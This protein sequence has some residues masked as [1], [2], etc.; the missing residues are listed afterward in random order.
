MAS[1]PKSPRPMLATL[2]K[3]APGG[4]DWIHELKLDG[5]RILGR[6]DRGAVSLI[7]R[8]GKDWIDRYP[9][10]AAALSG[11]SSVRA[12][13]DGEV[14]VLLPDGRTS[15]QALQSLGGGIGEGTLVY[16]VFDLLHLEGRDLTG[17]PVLERK[18]LLRELLDRF[19]AGEEARVR[20]S[21]HVRGRGREFHDRACQ[22][23]LEGIISKRVQSR[24]TEGRR[25]PDWLKVKC[26]HRQELIIVGYT[27]P[28]GSRS[29]FGAL[30]LGHFQDDELIYAG[31]VGTGFTAASIT[32]LMARLLPLETKRS[33]LSGKP[34]VGSRTPV[35]WVKPELVAEVEFTEWT[36]DGVLRHPSFQ[37]LREDRAPES[38]VRERPAGEQYAEPGRRTKAMKSKGSRSTPRS[39]QRAPGKA[40]GRSSR[41]TR[42]SAKRTSKRSGEAQVAGVRVTSRDRVVY[43][44]KGITKGEVLDYYE[45]VSPWLMPHLCDR[46]LTLV[47]C[48]DGA[49]GECFY[50]KHGGEGTPDIV[51]R[52]EIEQDAP[53]DE[54]YVY[55]DDL[56]AVIALVQLNVL[57]FHV[58]NAR[59]EQLDEPDQ[60]V[61][62]LDPGEGLPFERVVE[63]AR[64]VRDRLT[65]VGLEPFLKSTGGKGLH[66]MVPLRATQPWDA[67]KGFAKLVARV[68]AREQPDRYTDRMAKDER[69]GRIFIDYLRN[70]RNANQIAAYSTRAR[71]GATVSVPLRWDELRPSFDP[72]RY[73]IRTVL[74]RL[75]SLSADP[76]EGFDD[77]RREITPAM[78]TELR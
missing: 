77:A 74:R 5:Y 71:P 68:M 65:A 70:G 76:W 78:V 52:V 9:P 26:S 62:D 49:E 2:V 24:Y 42:Q 41:A 38:V 29:G 14:V 46:P 8:N 20:F 66:V 48:P 53:G 60:L 4:E 15:F 1:L 67:V 39:D 40:A 7:T 36:G 32:A 21:D 25:S 50:Q 47:R 22:H 63:A 45:A 55:I 37:G 58:W 64:D 69:H 33:P 35:H 11:W 56:P 6:V 18:A 10:V 17:L 57:E 61:F 28:S 59:V 44:A 13:L 43:P 54:P 23:E 51:P 31:R 12:L 30:L 16:Y 34:D 72:A 3:E 75:R 73:D 27:E 19:G